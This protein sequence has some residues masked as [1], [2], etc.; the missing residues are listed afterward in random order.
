MTLKMKLKIFGWIVQHHGN[1][2]FVNPREGKLLFEQQNT[3]NCSY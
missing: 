1:K 3:C 2:E